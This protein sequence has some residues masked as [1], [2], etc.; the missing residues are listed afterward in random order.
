M[1][2]ISVSA[3]KDLRD[4]FERVLQLIEIGLLL[5]LLI[6]EKNGSGLSSLSPSRSLSGEKGAFNP[7]FLPFLYLGEGREERHIQKKRK[8]RRRIR[9][10]A[11]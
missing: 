11:V 2:T 3:D 1:S 5:A 4:D 6:L 9:K 8:A 7:P 10:E